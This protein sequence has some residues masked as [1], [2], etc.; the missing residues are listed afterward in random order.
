[1]FH[2]LLLQ[3]GHVTGIVLSRKNGMAIVEYERS[4]H[5]VSFI[6]F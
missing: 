3:Y 6:I 1:M 4:S 5:A 2:V